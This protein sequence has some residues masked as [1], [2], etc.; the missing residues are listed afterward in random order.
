M[1]PVARY[2]VIWWGFWI[3]ANA[4]NL[5][6]SKRVEGNRRNS[7]SDTSATPAPHSKLI[8]KKKEEKWSPCPICTANVNLDSTE[9]SLYVSPVTTQEVYLGPCEVSMQHQHWRP[10]DDQCNCS[11]CHQ[12]LHLKCVRLVT[13]KLINSWSG[14]FV[15]SLQCPP[16]TSLLM[17][18]VSL[19]ATPELLLC[20][21]LIWKIFAIKF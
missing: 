10:H 13:R 7:T 15:M 4:K 17:S 8:S 12:F 14:P 16:W 18:H 20:Q 1:P 2:L 19:V 6:V 3:W 9:D 5:L 21:L 11:D